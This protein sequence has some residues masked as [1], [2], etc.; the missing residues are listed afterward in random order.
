MSG[1][2]VTYNWVFSGHWG[3]HFARLGIAAPLHAPLCRG[4]SV[5][6]RDR[7]CRYLRHHE[8]VGTHASILVPSHCPTHDLVFGSA[9]SELLLCRWHGIEKYTYLM[10][11]ILR[12]LPG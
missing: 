1:G 3:V 6:W 7:S 9:V 4:M 10:A 11:T 12:S 2:S 8:T 5:R